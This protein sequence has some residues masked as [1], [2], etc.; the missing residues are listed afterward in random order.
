MLIFRLGE[1]IKG[2]QGPR[3]PTGLPGL[4]GKCDCDKEDK[5][6]AYGPDYKNRPSRIYK[7]RYS[8]YRK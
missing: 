2:D 3:G 1:S 8:G 4:P 7:A 6:K 5:V